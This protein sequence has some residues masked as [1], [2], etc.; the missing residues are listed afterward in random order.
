MRPLYGTPNSIMEV[1]KITHCGGNSTLKN[2]ETYLGAA[3][4]TSP[5]TWE[6]NLTTPLT[7]GDKVTATISPDNTASTRSTSSFA[8]AKSFCA[9]S[10]ADI[11]AST[12]QLCSTD[13]AIL[14]VNTSLSNPTFKWAEISGSSPVYMGNS[15]SIN[16]GG[17]TYSVTVEESNSCMATAQITITSQ[18]NPIGYT[19]SKKH[20][21]NCTDNYLELSG[22]QIGVEYKLSPSGIVMQGTGGSITFGPVS[23]NNAA[24]QVRAFS[25]SPPKCE[26]DMSGAIYFTAAASLSVVPNEGTIKKCVGES[27]NF[28]AS[29]QGGTLP[30]SYFWSNNATSSTVSGSTSL[31]TTGIYH[32]TVTD[33]NGCKA[34]TS[35]STNLNNLVL[36]T[37]QEARIVTDVK[38]HGQSNGA[39]SITTNSTGYSYQWNP[40]TISSGNN[41]ANLKA[42]TYNVTMTKGLCKKILSLEVKQPADSVKVVSSLVLNPNVV[43]TNP[44]G[45]IELIVSGG[46]DPYS[47]SWNSTT[48]NVP[49]LQ[50]VSSGSYYATVTDSKGCSIKSKERVIPSVL[51]VGTSSVTITLCNSCTTTTLDPEPKGGT[52][53]Y[54]YKWNYMQTSP[55]ITIHRGN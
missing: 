24:Y 18:P 5:T 9:N 32:T 41:A 1:Y 45:K 36:D 13:K 47:Y 46:T 38:C 34:N 54:T 50:N 7:N 15:P 26:V 29:V 11:S 3:S 10:T 16:I 42:G 19:L 49:T 22:S 55:T 48:A 51:S 17:G 37:I 44:S 2:I 43:C 31:S 25:L 35:L 52:K 27:F 53:P 21:L 40:S 33:V 20:T 8:A 30:Y 39:I 23:N 14:S 6:L 4:M 28:S 12:T